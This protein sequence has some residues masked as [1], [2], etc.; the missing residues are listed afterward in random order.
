MSVYYEHVCQVP[1]RDTGLYNQCRPSGVLD[2]LQE[3]A[4][5]AACEIHISGPE[6]L[7]RYN[8]IWMVAR[9]WYRLER[10]IRWGDEV[11]I[12]T[13]HRGDRGAALYRD[14]DIS[15]NGQ[16]AGEA[17]TTWVLAD[18]DSRKLMRVSKLEEA[19]ETGGAELCKDRLLTKIRLPEQMAPAGYREFHYS[20]TDMNGHVN[21]VKYADAMADAL[22]LERLLPGHFVSSLQIGYLAECL[23]GERIGLY[24]GREGDTWFAHGADD[25]G[26][27]RFDGCLTLSP[28]PGVPAEKSP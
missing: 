12:R 2:L 21:N 18:V 7:A 4:T 3:A 10:P 5:A 17:V 9:M 22:H 1:A 19:L 25:G 11:A 15:I 28:L 13:W 24:T 27:S 14:F 26:K 20:D 8:A 6:M 16:W 23:A